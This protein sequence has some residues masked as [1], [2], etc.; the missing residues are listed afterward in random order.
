[1]K[2]YRDETDHILFTGDIHGNFSVI[3]D[4][5]K[6]RNLENCSI[7]F[8]GDI[9]LGFN[10]V[11]HYKEVFRVLTNTLRKRNVHLYFFRGNHDN[12]K[13][14]DGNYFL[15]H[16]HIHVISDYSIIQRHDRNILCVGG[17]ISI[18]RTLRLRKMAERMRLCGELGNLA[19]R[20][21]QVYVMETYWK[22]E[23]NVYDEAELNKLEK[24]GIRIDTVCTHTCPSFC[25]P[26]DK[27]SIEYWLSVDNELSKDLD[28]ERVVCDKLF[29]YLK[30]HGHPTTNWY[31][32]HFHEHKVEMIDGVK[33]T[34]LDMS[35]G[36][37][38]LVS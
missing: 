36:T 17:A 38:D 13:L 37:L 28:N 18:D 25:Y 7:V 34:L 23:P 5:V 31:Y 9:G 6:S 26:T 24:S 32:G 2:I 27:G 22:D 19:D 11:T 33:Y 29:E 14:F 16:K 30:S 3:E 4:E 20:F 15:R 10:T 35:R 21:A 1:M 8:C 12:R